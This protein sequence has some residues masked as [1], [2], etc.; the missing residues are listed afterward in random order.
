[1]SANAA[2]LGF[3]AFFDPPACRIASERAMMDVS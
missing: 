1:M 2:Q 3:I